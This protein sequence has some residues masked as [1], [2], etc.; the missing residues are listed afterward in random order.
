MC[1]GCVIGKGGAVIR[2]IRV[3]SSTTISIED[4]DEVT[5]QV[6]ATCYWLLATGY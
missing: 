4:P 2:D 5:P 3:Q 1:A 6:L